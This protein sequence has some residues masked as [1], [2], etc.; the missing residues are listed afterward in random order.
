MMTGG[1][2]QEATEKVIGHRVKHITTSSTTRAIN[3]ACRSA[4]LWTDKPLVDRWPLC[5][6]R[7]HPTPLPPRLKALFPTPTPRPLPG[8]CKPCWLYAINKR[9]R[10]R[11]NVRRLS[12][13]VYCVLLF[14][15]Q[16]LKI[17]GRRQYVLK[18]AVRPLT[19]I[20]HDT[21]SLY[22]VEGFG[23]QPTKLGTHIQHVIG[24][25]WKGFRGHEVK[26]QG[27]MCTSVWW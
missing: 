6:P 12:I 10:P 5:V 14:L 25:C 20:S 1:W 7:P 17:G 27:H 11:R 24:H 16:P 19:R 18:R 22:T 9:L 15:S 2:Q 8:P 26:G 3:H 23:F 4:P 13:F 21:V